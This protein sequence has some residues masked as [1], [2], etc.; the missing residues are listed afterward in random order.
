MAK[1]VLQQLQE[2]REL[3]PTPV[4]GL[5]YQDPTQ[6]ELKEMDALE[7]DE[8]LAWIF[9]KLV[10]DKSGNPV[11][12]EFQALIDARESEAGEEELAGLR[13]AADAVLETIPVGAIKKIAEGIRPFFQKALPRL[14]S[15]DGNSSAG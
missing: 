9:E 7:D 1:S 5:F 8:A 2:K 14:G 6:A 13:D 12:P 10:R 15:Q 3:S 11:A 4:A